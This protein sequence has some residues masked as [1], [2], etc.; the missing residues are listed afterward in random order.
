MKSDKF[1]FSSMKFFI[2]KNV[3]TK[4]RKKE[5]WKIYALLIVHVKEI[6]SLTHGGGDKN[7]V[8]VKKLWEF[9]KTFLS[10]H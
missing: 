6:F 8:W 10:S 5:D 2:I 1:Y 9:S 7:I 3:T 4:K